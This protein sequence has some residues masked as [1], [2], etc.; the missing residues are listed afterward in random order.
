MPFHWSIHQLT[1]YLVSVSKP[2][3]PEAV[4]TVAL[5]RS[6]E[7][8]DAEFGAVCIDGTSRGSTGFGRAGVPDAFVD[9]TDDVVR[10]PGI[11][12]VHLS[13]GALEEELG[14]IRAASRSELVIGRVD[15]PH[16]AEEHQLLQG[17]ALVLGLVLRNLE[18][19]RAE[20]SRHQLV[21]TLLAIQQAISARRPLSEL[22]DAITRGASNLLGG[23]PVVLLLSDGLTPGTLV[24]ASAFDVDELDE[25]TLTMAREVMETGRTR[26]GGHAV[27]GRPELMERVVVAGESTGCLVA[28]PS[29]DNAS[30]RDHGELLAAFAQ[31]VNLALTDARTLDAIREAYH[32]SITGLPN[33]ALF[34]ERLE[35]ARSLA[36]AHRNELT[37]LFVDLDRFK[38]VNDT[39]GHQVGDELL[40]EVGRR[41][42]T[43][44]RPS[45]TAARLG[46]DEFSILLEGADENTGCMVASRV[47]ADLSRAFVIAGREIFIGASVGIAQL[48]T[49]H[50]DAGSLLS[51]ADVAMYCAKRAGRGRWVVFEPSMSREL[52]NRLD[53]RTDLQ[54]A[55]DNG[56]LWLAYQPI[57]RIDSLEVDGVEALMRWDHPTRGAVPPVE[58]IPIAEET[59]TIVTLGAWALRQAVAQVTSWRVGP[60]SPRLSL[61]LSPR[62]LVDPSLPEVIEKVLESFSFPPEALTMEITESQLVSQ[63]LAQTRL[64]ALKDLGVSLAIDD[65]GTGYSSLSYL[66]QL[67]IDQVK[68]DK[69]FIQ[70]LAPDAPDAIA[71]M[72]GILEM[73]QGLRMQTLAE[74]I[75]E[76]VQLELLAE[77]GCDLG[78]G[79][80]LARPMPPDRWPEFAE[81]TAVPAVS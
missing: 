3:S 10:L 49:G 15:E 8:L 59:E 16:S 75:E 55:H 51:D 45:D 50:G 36:L 5:D 7:A 11:G 19:L 43:C 23:C 20:R 70:G 57:V 14:G 63:E 38:A 62:Q 77:L 9:C 58:F 78:Q 25:V 74:G 30:E 67:P 79:Y 39:L 81:R 13:R 54:H 69:S 47:I 18:T 46:G 41:I 44:I 60:S 40:A 27:E 32:D 12:E 65:F 6:V 53:L 34:L 73:C 68:I 17:M 37:V 61:N 48:T 21:R 64:T 28:R 66:R 22:L 26:S 31:Q 35:Q 42:R 56:Q 1:E 72:R 33:R 24:P 52:I 29:P 4:I 76:P 71:V 80:H 2:Q